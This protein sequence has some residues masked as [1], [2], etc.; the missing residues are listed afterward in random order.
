MVISSQIILFLA[1]ALIPL[2][3]TSYSIDN[4]S[5]HRES[6]AGN[7]HLNESLWQ[8]FLII[9]HWPLTNALNIFTPGKLSAGEK[10]CVD[11]KP[12]WHCLRK[13]VQGKCQRHP[14]WAARKCK[15]S[16]NLCENS[17][18][19]SKSKYVDISN[20]LSFILFGYY[21]N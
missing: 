19:Y 18:T 11:L 8:N 17:K 3:V 15:K 9:S 2:Y 13:Q 6:I 7:E 14:K 20:L 10:P 16:C 5:L 21:D 1:I 4:K 12:T